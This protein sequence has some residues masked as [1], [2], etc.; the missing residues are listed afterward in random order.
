VTDISIF[1]QTRESLK[2]KDQAGRTTHEDAGS[3]K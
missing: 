3:N 1:V 2:I